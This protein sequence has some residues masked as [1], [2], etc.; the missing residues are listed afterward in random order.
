[1]THRRCRVIILPLLAAALA[2][3]ACDLV[4][5]AP[6]EDAPRPRGPSFAVVFSPNGEPLTGGRLDR[7][8]CAQALAGWFERIDVNH[9]GFIDRQEFL[10]DAKAEFARM[11]MDHDGFITSDELS[12]YRAPFLPA[13]SDRLAPRDS[14][15]QPPAATPA[16]AEERKRAARQNRG[17][18]DLAA[19]TVPAGI[20]DPVMSADTNLDFKVSQREFLTQAEEVFARFD[21]DHDGRLSPVEIEDQGCKSAANRPVRVEY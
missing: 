21:A 11:D 15:R 8:A 4:P 20:A 5:R 17:G 19:R 16:Q 3:S 13:D 10:D 1:M 6:W 9:D 14:S 18:G 12:V 2:L 7:A